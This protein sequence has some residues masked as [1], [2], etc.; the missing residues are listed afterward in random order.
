M[1]LSYSLGGPPYYYPQPPFSQHCLASSSCVAPPS[2]ALTTLQDLNL[3]INVQIR[4][5]QP[6]NSI[7]QYTDSKHKKPTQLSFREQYLEIPAHG[8]LVH[9]A[10]H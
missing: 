4:N 9:R 2:T 7:H 8:V 6:S 3:D 10:E 1:D 5:I